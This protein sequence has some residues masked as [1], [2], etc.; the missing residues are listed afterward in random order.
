MGGQDRHR[1]ALAG[2]GAVFSERVERSRW[3]GNRPLRSA[4][5]GAEDLEA[6]LH[7]LDGLRDVERGA[8]EVDV[9][10][11]QSAGFTASYA[12][13]E[14]QHPQGMKPV[15]RRRVQELAGFLDRQ[16]FLDGS[17]GSFDLDETS[18]IT[19]DQLFPVS[20]FECGAEGGVDVLDGPCADSA[21]ARDGAHHISRTSRTEC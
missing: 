10:P 9:F 11:A 6:A 16:R 19:A 2:A 15:S 1:A 3:Q 20:V 5:L 14:Q 21:L 18:H 12:E 13:H 8:L 7:A 4:G 17:L